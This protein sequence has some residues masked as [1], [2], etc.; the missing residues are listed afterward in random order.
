MCWLTVDAP[1]LLGG[2]IMSQ[3]R[4]AAILE[5]KYGSGPPSGKD[6]LL[7]GDMDQDYG[8]HPQMAQWVRK[9]GLGECAPAFCL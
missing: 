6:E 2:R 1:S 8:V 3:A 4:D 9:I 5:L 7:P